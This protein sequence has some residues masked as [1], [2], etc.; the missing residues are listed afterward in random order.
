M[1][2]S[3]RLM[4]KLK[5]FRTAIGFHDAYVAAASRAAALRA[6]GADSDLFAMGAAEV[7]ADGKLAAAPLSEPGKVFKVSRG[8]SMEH[9]SALGDPRQSGKTKPPAKPTAAKRMKPRPSR[10]K[11]DRVEAALEATDRAHRS[12]LAALDGQ[13]EELR[14]RRGAIESKHE[15]GRG[16]LERQVEAAQAKHDAAMAQWR[17]STS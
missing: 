4:P 5:V 12:D 9:L 17:K 1:A 16:K 8:T 6:W 15:E 3:N 14:R 10:Q 11:L 2:G 13:I 7:V